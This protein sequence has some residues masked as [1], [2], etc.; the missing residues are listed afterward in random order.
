MKYFYVN[1]WYIYSHINCCF[2]F[3]A[4]VY[5][6]IVLPMIYLDIYCLSFMIEARY[7]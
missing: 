4:T 1:H 6:R 3:S 5:V 7:E 2:E